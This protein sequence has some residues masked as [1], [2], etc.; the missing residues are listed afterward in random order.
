MP[1]EIKFKQ[2]LEYVNVQGDLLQTV[3]E[4]NISSANGRKFTTFRE[5]PSG[6]P[7]AVDLD[8][9]NFM[10]ELDDEDAFIS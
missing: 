7:I 5:H 9:I 10:R 6:T 3:H 4:L 1:V 8:N 2:E